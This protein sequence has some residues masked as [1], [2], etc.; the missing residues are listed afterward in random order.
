MSDMEEFA[1]KVG[2]SKP[3]YSERGSLVAEEPVRCRESK[4]GAPQIG[5]LT[6]YAN[7]AR[8]FLPT[9]STVSTLPARAYKLVGYQEGVVLEPLNIVT[10]KL[11]RFPDSRSDEVIAEVKNFWKLKTKFKQF[12]FSH[13]R[14]FL[15]WG[16]PGSGKTCTIAIIIQNMLQ[17]EGVVIIAESP[18]YLADILPNIR[19][20]EPERPIIVIW[21]DLDAVIDRYGESE[22]LAILDGESQVENIVFIATTNY[23]EKLDGRIVNRP[24]RFDKIVKI[25]MPNEEARKMYL[26]DKIGTTQI[27]GIDLI[28]STHDFSIAHLRELI[29]GIKCLGNSPQEV[30]SRL[31]SMKKKPKSSDT[32]HTLGLQ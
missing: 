24:S 10:D 21:E 18:R 8:G 16:P 11:M 3:E 32:G 13:K 19:S 15:I 14:G 2:T 27:D 31:S 1:S 26:M 29:V 12:G 22:V 17:D 6:Q 9:T 23:P 4:E 28:K 30:I 7:F 20:V 5:K 25:G